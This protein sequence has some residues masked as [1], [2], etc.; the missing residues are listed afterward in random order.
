MWSIFLLSGLEPP[1]M[2]PLEIQKPIPEEQQGMQME[3]FQ[4]T[5]DQQ[6]VICSAGALDTGKKLPHAYNSTGDRFNN[7]LQIHAARCRARF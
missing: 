6:E 7:E 4:L 3:T 5:I 2:P 1:P